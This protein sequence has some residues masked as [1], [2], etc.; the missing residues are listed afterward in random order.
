MGVG[1]ASRVAG[2][3]MGGLWFGTLD[4][5]AWVLARSGISHNTVELN[6]F[7]SGASTPSFGTDMKCVLANPPPVW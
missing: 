5:T 7:K 1:G 2:D 4:W 6:G 3:R